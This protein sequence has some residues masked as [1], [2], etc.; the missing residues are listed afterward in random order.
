MK[1]KITIR[2][3]AKLAGVSSATVS[4]VVNGINKVSEE[5]KEKVF[6]A[7]KQLDYQP[8]FTAISLSKRKSNMLGVMMPFVD[9]SLAPMFRENYYYT[10]MIGGMESIARKNK[11]DLLISGVRDPQDCKSWVTKRNLDGLIFLGL[12]PEAL[13][14]E[15]KSLDIPI[16]LIDNYEEFGKSYHNIRI[17]DELGGYLAGKH[18]IERGHR[19]ISF[20]GHDLANFPVDWNRSNGLKKAVTE[21]KL[22]TDAITFFEGKGSSFEIGYEMGTKLLELGDKST[23]IFASSDILAMGIIKALQERGKEIPHD[24][25][26][27]GFDDL[28]INMISRPGLTTIRQDV[29]NKGVVSAQTIIDAIEQKISDPVHVT[30]SIELVERESTRRLE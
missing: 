15:L 24:Y 29:F 11:Y 12:F 14:E 8:D 2:D 5:T 18:L 4:Y 23:A 3:V 16:V 6:E 22:S 26:I 1:Q 20:I 28:A 10:E 7:I 25:S 9:N 21:A 17:D 13:Y 19:A 30:L 27:V